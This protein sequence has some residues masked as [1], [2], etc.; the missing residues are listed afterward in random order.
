MDVFEP[1]STQLSSDIANWLFL[2]STILFILCLNGAIFAE[3]MVGTG[4]PIWV[5]GLWFWLQLLFRSIDAYLV[6]NEVSPA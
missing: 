2:R 4:I 6:D 5:I 1:D 3:S